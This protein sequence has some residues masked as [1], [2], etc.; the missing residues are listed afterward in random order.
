MKCKTRKFQIITTVFFVMTT[1]LPA[2]SSVTLPS[3]L[4][5]NMVLQQGVPVHIWGK[6]DR[7]EKVSVRILDQF[8]K[9]VADEKGNWQIWLHPMKSSEPVSMTVSGNNTIVIKNILIG[10]VWF[11]AGQS[12]ME[13]SVSK[14]DNS[15]K[16]IANANYPQIRIFDAKRCFSDTVKDD[17][18]GKWVMC[19]PG[20]VAEI[21]ATG[22]FFTRGIHQHLRIPVGLIDAS[23][24]ATRC[25]A[26]TPAAC[27]KS[28]P[29][30]NYWLMKWEKYQQDFP[31]LKEE[32]LIQYEAW[33][34]EAE[35]A[36]SVGKEIP[37]EPKVPEP[38]TKFEPSVIYNGVVAPVSKY[39]IRGVIW[40]QGENNAYKE[41]AYPYR[42]LFPT[43]IDAWRREWKQGSFPFIFAQ[44]STLNKHPYWPVLRESQ[45]EALKLKNT[46]MIVTYDI[47]DSTD[48]HFKNKQEVGKRFE[49]AARKLVYGENIAASGPMFRQMTIE[50]NTL[51]IWFENSEGLK[52]S[53][54]K[55]LL[56]FEIAEANGKLHPAKAAI[57]G[58]TILLSNESVVNPSV[59]RYAFKDAT[60]GNLI[61]GSGLPAVP[62][63][64][65]VKNSL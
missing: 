65:D 58:E 35:K 41:E 37:K 26:W 28:D 8:Q 63:R 43:M 57:D 61:N 45:T 30:L 32:Y 29:R 23:W 12:N 14:S 18:E 22:Y 52:S 4:S 11:A 48:A 24:G 51:R 27:F 13:Y 40:Y 7:G 54:G 60:I 5:D 9:T 42:Y 20:T 31:R 15:E 3:L 25:E 33:K 59:A 44:L 39:T 46:A 62:F 36:R 50:G 55:E 21:T 34:T 64:T 6:A 2:R 56:G 38:K 10:E 49:L 47:G 53:D 1:L 17:I 16:E 19:S